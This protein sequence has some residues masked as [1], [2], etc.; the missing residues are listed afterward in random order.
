MNKLIFNT[1]SDVELIKKLRRGQF[2]LPELDW[3]KEVQLLIGKNTLSQMMKSMSKHRFSYII[4]YANNELK[5]NINLASLEHLINYEI[6]KYIQVKSI[7]KLSLIFHLIQLWGGNAARFFYF[8]QAPI[9]FTEYKNFINDILKFDNPKELVCSLKKLIN[10]QKT[11]YFNIAFATKHISLWQRFGT[12][13]KNP[14]PIYD[15]IMAKNVMGMCRW[16]KKTKKWKGD[17]TNDWI[18][19]KTYW[20]NM[21]HVARTN[22]ISTANIERQVFN[23]FRGKD[24]QRNYS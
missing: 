9:D 6:K 23:Y 20:S 4:D 15:S 5:D 2:A 13:L 11:K 16:D 18:S 7:E 1:Q 8:N 10:S 12:S 19:L 21:L 14:L 3:E 17:A 22:K 24:W